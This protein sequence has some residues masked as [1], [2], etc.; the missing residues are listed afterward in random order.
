MNPNS[1]SK[2]FHF[3]CRNESVFLCTCWVNKNCKSNENLIP[4]ILALSYRNLKRI[5]RFTFLNLLYSFNANSSKVRYDM[6]IFAIHVRSTITSMLLND[7]IVINQSKQLLN[8]LTRGE[9]ATSLTR[10]TQFKSMNTFVRSYY[11][12]Y[13]YY[14]TGIRRR[15]Y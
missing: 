10:E 14:K 2:I 3:Y 5:R 4:Q 9:W 7:N 8:I 12:I 15:R 11:Y 13:M 1:W 6:Q